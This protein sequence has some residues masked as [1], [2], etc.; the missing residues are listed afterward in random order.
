MGKKAKFLIFIMAAALLLTLPDLTFGAALPQKKGLG[1]L[2]PTG[3]SKSDIAKEIKRFRKTRL[4]SLPAVSADS[5]KLTKV[6]FEVEK[7]ADIAQM[8]KRGADISSRRRG[9]IAAKVPDGKIE[10]IVRNVPGVKFA[11]PPRRVHPCGILSEG[12]GLTGAQDAHL[13]GFAGY[14]VKIALIDVGFK[15]LAEAIT[16][17]ELP[18]AVVTHDFSG[19]GLET[20][21]KHGTAVAEIVHDMASL[22][23]LHLLKVYDEFD[24]Y[25][26]FDYCVENGIKVVNMSIGTFGTGPGDG[27]G[28]LDEACNALKDAGILLVAAAGNFGNTLTSDEIPVGSHWEGVFIDADSDGYHEF[29]PGDTESIVNVVAAIPMQDDD[30]NPEDGE[31]SVLLRWD[32][33]VSATTDYDM[34]LLDENFEIAGFSDI[35]QDGTQPPVEYISIDLPDSEDYYHI[36]Y[37]IIIRG[38]GEPAGK[39]MELY[40][41]GSSIFIPLDGESP[42]QLIA[43]SASS[44]SEPA[45]AIGVLAAGAIDQ[46]NWG[47]GPQEDF[48]SQGPTNDWGGV[49]PRIKPDICGPDGTSGMTYGTQSFYGT[50]AAAPHVAGAAALILSMEPRLTV[51]ELKQ[52]LLS[53]AQDIGASGNDNIYGS[54]ALHIEALRG[55]ST[56]IIPANFN[57]NAAEDL[58]IDFGRHGMHTYNDNF[59]WTQ[60]HDLD[61]DCLAAGDMDAN[62]LDEIVIDF[63]SAGL[64]IRWDSGVWQRITEADADYIVTADID[65][66]GRAA[67]IGDFGSG[68]IHIYRSVSGWMQLHELDCEDI[69]K[70]DVDAD[71]KD[72][73]II[74]FGNLGVYIYGVDELWRPLH[75]LNPQSVISANFDGNPGEDLVVDFGEDKGIFIYYNGE[76]WQKLHDMSGI[77]YAAGNMDGVGTDEVIVDFGPQYGL[78]I[79]RGPLDWTHLH[80]LSSE[81]ITCCDLDGNGQADLVVDFGPQYGIWIYYNNAVWQLLNENS[82]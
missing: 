32:D 5:N 79:S 4:S 50:S 34:Y 65:V 25:S 57:G 27:T 40:L 74:D 59:A 22:A 33:W 75:Q 35:T 76:I 68:G 71:G 64:W 63:G 43:T 44:L 60:I 78:F 21:Y 9:L 7:D 28:S 36:Y 2:R 53:D 3:A 48:S 1:R 14:G 20:Q 26:A 56:P 6:I 10:E 37:L 17:G 41:G 62:G 15:G 46:S 73:L 52:A 29:M 69:S 47:S 31:V 42:D 55:S 38:S 16:A 81:Y 49:S 24:I 45:D 12:V 82:P 11:R 66:N 70:A 51:D 80:D 77:H 13:A 39:K 54:G 30:D 8:Q 67:V 58:L 61:P 72:E 23:E 19:M 18:P